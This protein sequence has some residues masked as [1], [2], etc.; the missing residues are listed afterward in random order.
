MDTFTFIAEY[1]GSTF[2]SQ[3]KGA[4][5][6]EACVEW[7]KSLAKNAE[8]TLKNKASFVKNLKNDLEEMPPA[9]LDD[10]PNV[11]YFLADAGKDY[12]HVNA[13]K[14]HPAVNGWQKTEARLNEDLSS[15]LA[16]LPPRQ[17][18]EAYAE[19]FEE[20]RKDKPLALRE[21]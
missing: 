15:I 12:I 17:D 18:F 8:I 9:R 4:T 10:T 14:T 21:N 1:K 13:V 5:I 16:G 2:I 6:S 11:W 3:A 19:E 7:G 20:S